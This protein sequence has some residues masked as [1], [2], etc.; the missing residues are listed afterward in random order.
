MVEGKLQ[1][2]NGV[3]HVVTHECFNLSSLLRGMTANQI[4]KQDLQ[5]CLAE[6]RKAAVQK[7]F[8]IKAVISGS[9]K[10]SSQENMK[11]NITLYTR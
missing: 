10:I 6:T 2:A 7:N 8:S 5:R 1:V 9:S 4:P 11:Y 3:T